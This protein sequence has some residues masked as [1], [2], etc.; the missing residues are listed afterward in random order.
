V[1]DEGEAG[2]VE[3]IAMTGEGE[4]RLVIAGEDDVEPMH[5]DA[6]LDVVDEAIGVVDIDRD[7]ARR[8]SRSSRM[9]TLAGRDRH[10]VAGTPERP[11]RRQRPALRSAFDDQDSLARR[12]RR[13]LATAIAARPASEFATA[14]E[15]TGRS[16]VASF[17]L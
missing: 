2:G 11:R 8:P 16:S 9:G 15:C 5:L 4:E 10:F 7:P 1:R 3:S 17:H 6:S 14:N 12:H 13:R